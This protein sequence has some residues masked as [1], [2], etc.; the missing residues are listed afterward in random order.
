MVNCRPTA[1]QSSTAT[2]QLTTQ[3]ILI[4][5]SIPLL[6][7]AGALR[8]THPTPVN[9]VFKLIW[10]LQ[11]LYQTHAFT[12]V[13]SASCLGFLIFAK[14]GKRAAVKRPGGWWLRFVPEILI[15]VVTVT[16]K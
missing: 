16:S 8:N 1:S 15:L 2:V 5:Q 10:V 14:V 7:L 9:P 6:G 13:L 3:I 4:E 11:N 12:A